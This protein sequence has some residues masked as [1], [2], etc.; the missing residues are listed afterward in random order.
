VV[1]LYH[2]DLPQALQDAGGWVARDT[3]ARFADYAAMVA[4]ALGDRVRHWTTLNE[5]WCSAFLGY[6]A[7]L[8][9]P[10]IADPAQAFPAAHH[11]LLGHGLATHA[12]RAATLARAQISLVLNPVPVTPASDRPADL[13]AARR[14]DAVHNRLF[15]D[16][17]LRG[18]YPVDLPADAARWTDW[19]FVRPGDEHVV[20]A[21]LD[22]LGVNY[23]QPV[24]VAAGPPSQPGHPGTAGTVLLP[25]PGPRTAMEWQIEPRGLLDVLLRIHTEYPRLPLLVTENGAAFDDRVGADGRVHDADRIQ[26]LDGHLRAAHAALQRGVD[27]RGFFVW[28]FLDNFEWAEGFSKRFGIVFVEYGTQRRVPK[29]SARWYA[30]VIRSNGLE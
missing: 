26:F 1:T 29:S 16:P 12:I 3:A 4:G 18:H 5:P 25:A 15:L 27:L 22:M 10:G 24:R 21:P 23:Y 6:A 9:A 14:V 19:S 8:H 7:G 28:S 11:L 2:W 20:S 13:D 30:G 17:V